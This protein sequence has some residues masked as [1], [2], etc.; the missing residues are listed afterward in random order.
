M[1]TSFVFVFRRRLQDASIKTNIFALLVHFLDVLKM[2]S[3]RAVK[4]GN[5][6][7]QDNFDHSGSF[8]NGAMVRIHK[9][10]YVA[11]ALWKLTTDV[12]AVV[13]I[14]YEGPVYIAAI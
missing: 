9:C 2:S 13:F 5:F 6:Y 8:V 10:L 1:K 4:R 11:S 14:Y 3:S 12:W 7:L